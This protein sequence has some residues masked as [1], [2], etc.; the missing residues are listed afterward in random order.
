MKQLAV[1]L[2]VLSAF[3]L[4]IPA[5]QAIDNS[6]SLAGVRFYPA[7]HI[8]NVPITTMPVDTKSAGLGTSSW[9][10]M[11]RGMPYN[12]VDNTVVHQDV[13]LLR[14]WSDHIK[15]PI[16]QNPLIEPGGVDKHLLIVDKDDGMFYE[17]YKASMQTDGTL[18]AQSGFSFDLNS[19]ALRTNGL[20]TAC[21]AGLPIL[22]GLVRY[23]E[24]SSGVINHA[25]RVSVP[26]TNHS[27]VWPARAN[28]NDGNTDGRYPA[29]GQR[30]RLKASFDTSGYS[31]QTKV[32]L[33]ALKKYGMMVS[34]MNGETGFFELTA[35]P[36][37][38]WN[39]NDLGGLKQVHGSDFEA[40]DV[41]SLMINVNSGQAR[42]STNPIPPAAAFTATPNYLNVQFTSSSTGTAPLTYA[43]NFGDGSTSTLQ[44]P[45]HTYAAAGTYSVKLTVTNTAGSNAVTKSVTASA[46]PAVIP[47][48]AAFSATA[49]YLNVQFTSSSTGTAPLTYAWN[50][51]DGSTSTLQNPAHTYATAGTYSV[52][53]TVTN[54][55][56][57]NAVTKSVTASAAPAVI[58]PTAA[59]S[60]TAELPQRPVYQLHQRVLLPLPMP[61][62]SGMAAPQPCKTR[63]IPMQLRVPT[64][65]N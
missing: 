21:E 47:P 16:P 7:D 42:T 5:V 58:P 40:V 37:T 38:R 6:A 49:N 48:T 4:A 43:W 65:L 56:G 63:R 17:F 23:D 54:S 64:P 62:I 55:A 19:Y 50:F 51:G 35:A 13:S 36:D 26:A 25:L 24:V 33:E 59:F 30:Y 60:A 28:G 52:K 27:Y 45:A 1:I 18:Y 39:T 46:A 20:T 22:P 10:G 12:L 34:G 61:G 11:Y 57:S 2:L 53:L 8:W 44:N 29:M 15:Y 9:L 32:I 14:S 31:P 3:L 41:S